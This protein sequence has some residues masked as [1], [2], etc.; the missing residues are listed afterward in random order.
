MK[1]VEVK[2]DGNCLFNSVTLA[3]ENTI[4]FPHET[5]KKAA[6]VIISDP[7]VFN[8]WELERKDP[9]EYVAWLCGEEKPW[10]GLPELKAL[11][12]HYQ[13]ELAVVYFQDKPVEVFG[14][15]YKRRVYLLYDGYHYDLLASEE[16][17]IFDQ[18]DE[19][20]Y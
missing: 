18:V 20:A 19:K 5:R 7:L 14:Q 15:N 1:R 11:A 3:I 17:K 2:G 4:E 8:K 10:G 6:A 13:T 12:M 9:Q 16:S